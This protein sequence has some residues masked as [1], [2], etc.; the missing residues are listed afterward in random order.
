MLIL[1]SGATRDVP[2]YPPERV[3]VLVTPATGNSLARVAASGRWWAADNAAFSGFDA[4]R[5]GAMLRGIRSVDT[6][7]LL[8]VASP[9]YVGHARPTIGEFDRWLDLIKPGADEA[10]WLPIALVAQDGLEDADWSWWLGLTDCLFIGGSTEWKLSHAADGL[11][12][13][14]RARGVWVHVGRVNTRQRVEHFAE[15]G[16]DSIDGSGFSRW[17]SRIKQGVRWVSRATEPRLA[18]GG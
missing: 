13:E 11:I 2:S 10:D 18:F 14:A 15:V 8:W 6:C 7:R 17:P 12:R 5:F 4:A 9:D 16:V 3:G 1:V